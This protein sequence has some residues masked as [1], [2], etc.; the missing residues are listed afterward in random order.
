MLD[1]NIQAIGRDKLILEETTKM[2]RSEKVQIKKTIDI[3]CN[4]A[5]D[6]GQV[7]SKEEQRKELEEELQSFKFLDSQND[8]S[9][10]EEG[11]HIFGQLV[12]MIC[13]LMQVQ[14][15]KSSAKKMY[16]IFFK[17]TQIFLSKS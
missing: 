2:H 16:F 3:N 12:N 9:I 8:K 10:L 4:N 5:G 14:Y 11:K 13:K 7:K 1:D 6:I 15:F 17:M